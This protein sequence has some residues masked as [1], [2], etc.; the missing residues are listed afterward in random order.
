MRSV[1]PLAGHGLRPAA[2]RRRA[3]RPQLKRDPLGSHYSSAELSMPFLSVPFI[4]M[5]GGALNLAWAVAWVAR[6]ISSARWPTTEG[7][8]MA[9]VLDE[10]P[11]KYQPL[12][13]Y[14]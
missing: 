14:Q 13:E 4:M 6:A 2:L 10:S 1:V 11:G 7:L 9:R 8:I 5:A 3:R 12:L